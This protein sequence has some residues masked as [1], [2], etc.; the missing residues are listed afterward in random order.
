MKI[1]VYHPTGNEN[2]R[3]LLR[4]LKNNNMLH[5]FHTTIAVFESSW[6]YRFLKAKLS[7]FKRR[8]YDSKI[9]K[10]TIL[11]PFL[12]ILLFAGKKTY[13][14]EK[15][16]GSFINKQ[17]TKSVANYVKRNWKTIDGVYGYPFGSY[18]VFCE[19]KRHNIK[20]FYEL[21]TIYYKEL[22]EITNKEKK[23]NPQYNSTI[24]IYE[25]S[26]EI[27]K[28]IDL[29]L[30]LADR[31]IVSST[32]IK[33]SLVKY[34]V[35]ENKIKI[36]PYGFPQISSKKYDYDGKRKLK[37]LFAGNLSQ[38]KG[39]SYM[40]EAVNLFQ[41]KIILTLAGSIADKN[42]R[43]LKEQLEKHRYLGAVSHVQ[44]LYEMGKNDILLFPSLCDGF[45]LVITE[46]MSQGTPVIASVNSAG[47]DL[48]EN[49]YNGWLIPVAD[50]KI[51]GNILNMIIE[52][53]Q[54]VELNGKNATQTALNRPWSKYEN[55]IVNF[56][57]KSE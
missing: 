39:L 18:D 25:E 47:R 45:G 34:G 12:E 22:K 40:F 3:A 17:L 50:S 4:A 26:N 14:G 54:L 41:D 8:T 31:I 43:I 16:T 38:I 28:K 21:T 9:K 46:S 5:S 13:K 51:I 42:N 30:N 20:C 29:E 32:F 49:N 23:K 10:Q 24:S 33:E 36:I 55:D 15:L 53:P 56:I 35:P 52:M 2:V 37:V 48:I 44:L 27:L 1:L 6:Y 7:R 11:Y 19:A 57:I